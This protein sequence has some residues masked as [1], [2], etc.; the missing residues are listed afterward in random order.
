MNR[1]TASERRKETKV[2]N[3][4]AVGNTE[5][6]AH[7]PNDLEPE[8]YQPDMKCSGTQTDLTTSDLLAVEDDYRKRLEELSELRT[9]HAKAYPEQEDL[10]ND[11]KMCHFYTGPDSYTVLIALFQIVSS[12]IH[13]TPVVKR[14]RF[15]SFTLILMK[16]RLNQNNYDLACQFGVSEAKVSRVFMMD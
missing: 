8:E 12:A 13:E 10:N 1:Y 7:Q 4:E 5:C 3:E 14:T 9:R 16:L 11:E 2:R 6:D 15:R